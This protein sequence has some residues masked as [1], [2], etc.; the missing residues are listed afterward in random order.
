MTLKHHR[1][2]NKIIYAHIIQD[3]QK[4]MKQVI[5]KFIH[6]IYEEIVMG[7]EADNIW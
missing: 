3:R 2:K 4:G 5:E 6:W 7:D 1:S